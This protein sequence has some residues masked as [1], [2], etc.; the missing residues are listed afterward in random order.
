MFSKNDFIVEKDIPIIYGTDKLE[1]TEQN[2]N[3]IT[4]GIDIFASSFFMLT[5]WEEYVNKNR[6]RH[7][8][9]PAIES[10]AFKNDF[11][12]RPVVNEYVEMF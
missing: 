3:I 2:Q 5:R 12:S 9:F 10:L 11:L 8:R 7:N 4:C 1:I 6:D